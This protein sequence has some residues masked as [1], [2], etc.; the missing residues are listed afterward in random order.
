M[1]FQGGGFTIFLPGNASN[2]FK[3]P[4]RQ[5]NVLEQLQPL[6]KHSG[7]D[8]TAYMAVFEQTKEK[9]MN[10]KTENKSRKGLIRSLVFGLLILSCLA[11]GVAVLAGKNGGA[12]GRPQVKVVLSG[13]VERDNE[14]V[15]LE[16]ADEVRPGEILHWTVSSENIGDGN[17]GDYKVVG[18]IPAGTQFVEGSAK[19][20]G[21]P[22][23]TYSIDGGKSF[24]KQPMIEEKQAD[25]SVKRVPAPASMFTQLR[26]E[27]S[28]PLNSKENL[29]A[30]YDVVVK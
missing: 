30:S 22:V 20:E 24:S 6:S 28:E 12:F 25:G 4:L 18:R 21:A 5:A 2:L 9:N 17:A 26:F 7:L 8:A 10:T 23:V 13:A 3:S 1:L 29:K 14:M 19:A 15:S 11:G 27:W 16:K